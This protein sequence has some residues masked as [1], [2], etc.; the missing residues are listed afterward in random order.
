MSKH[1]FSSYDLYH[2]KKS[3]LSFSEILL[4]FLT[5]VY[6]FACTTMLTVSAL[7]AS[8]AHPLF[9][10]FI[11]FAAWYCVYRVLHVAITCLRVGYIESFG[12]DRTFKIKY[13]QFSAIAFV[14]DKRVQLARL[15]SK[16]SARLM[17]AHRAW[18]RRHCVHAESPIAWLEIR[19]LILSQSTYNQKPKS[20]ISSNQSP[21]ARSSILVLLILFKT[22]EKVYFNLY[23]V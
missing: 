5:H 10:R 1:I 8:S 21:T 19:P 17:P 20:L 16:S 18:G 23:P 11:A 3:S 9:S 12:G 14:P 22:N 2:W 7:S 13:I 6:S 15:F 4:R